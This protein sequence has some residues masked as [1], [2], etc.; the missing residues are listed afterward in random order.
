MAGTMAKVKAVWNGPGGPGLTQIHVVNAGETVLSPGEAQ[1]AVSALQTYFVDLKGTLPDDWSVSVDPVT[2]AY[3]IATGQLTGS[4][5]APSTPAV[6]V[7]TAAGAWMGG[8]G[9]LTKLNTGVIRNGRRVVG[10][11]FFVPA[12]A[13]AFEPDGTP[14][15]LTVTA[16]QNALGNMVS[17][18]SIGGLDLVVWSRPLVD[19]PLSGVVSQVTGWVCPNRSAIL[20]SRRD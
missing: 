2:D 3:A 7:G 19:V 17:N 20:R 16:L 8:A 1:S 14:G 4:T 13:A 9:L 10:K 18:L 12:T 5:T 15:P 11:V 6:V